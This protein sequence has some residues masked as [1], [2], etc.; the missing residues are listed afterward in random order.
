MGNTFPR[1]L[2]PF[3]TH[4]NIAV[5]YKAPGATYVD[6][7]GA[8]DNAEFINVSKDDVLAYPRI[9]HIAYPEPVYAHMETAVRPFVEACMGVNN[10]IVNIFNRQLGLPEGALARFHTR[11]EHSIC[12]AR[13]VRVPPSPNST[14]IAVGAHTDFGRFGQY[15]NERHGLV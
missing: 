3:L 2:D 6:L 15:L 4:S 12:E 10:T 7:N 11:D 5:S 8:K 9:V 13:V 1:V 14:K